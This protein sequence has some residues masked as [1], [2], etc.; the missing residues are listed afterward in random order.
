MPSRPGIGNRPDWANRPGAGGSGTPWRPGNGNR[1]DWANRPGAGGS[2][3]PWR[4]GR[5]NRPDYWA[6]RPGAGNGNPWRPGNGDRPWANGNRPWGIGNRPGFVNRPTNNIFNQQNNITN[7]Q[8]ANINQNNLTSINRPWGYNAYHANWAGWHA[9]HWNNWNSCPSAWFGAGA[10]TAAAGNWMFSPGESYAY[11][12]P[13]YVQP[14]T[15]VADWAPDYSQAIAVPTPVVSYTDNSSAAQNYVAAYGP[16]DTAQAPVESPPQVSQEAPPEEPAVEPQSEVPPEVTQDFE[17]AREA[18]KGGEYATSLK[19]IDAA[20]KG[21][22]GDATLHEFRALVLFAQKK[23]KDAAA[24]IY[25]VLSVGPGMN[26]DTMSGLYPNVDTYQQQLRA[27]EAYQRDHPNAS[28]GHFLL[29]YH[30][31]VMGYTAQA[32]KQLE[33]VSKLVP[34]DKLTP[35]LVKAFTQEPDTGKP[36][37]E[38]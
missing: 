12:N 10:A 23:Y 19:M 1:P 37:A 3:S 4:P 20:I 27:L 14:A 16:T 22:P 5:G 26:W 28:D 6:N 33:Y 34:T 32:V 21:L 24:G 18:F 36:K 35:E 15:A 13:F 29:A 8:F 17:A 7:N 25:A 2:G 9:G 30:Y 38:G 31:L 11:S